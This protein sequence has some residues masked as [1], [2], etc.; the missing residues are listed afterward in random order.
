MPPDQGGRGF[1][2]EGGRGRMYR[3]GSMTIAT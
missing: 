2:V 1:T 3:M